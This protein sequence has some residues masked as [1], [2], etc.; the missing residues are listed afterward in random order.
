M[1]LIGWAHTKTDPWQRRTDWLPDCQSELDMG[2]VV[3]SPGM[4]TCLV[5][6]HLLILFS[7]LHTNFTYFETSI[8]F[9]E[10]RTYSN[11]SQKTKYFTRYKIKFYEKYFY[12]YRNDSVTWQM[13]DGRW[14]A[15]DFWGCPQIWFFSCP[16]RDPINDLLNGLNVL[17]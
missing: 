10:M 6:L 12:Q 4:C 9:I 17:A 3:L 16:L 13:V 15:H 1:S 11:D 14:P 2:H 8:F 5:A 7:R